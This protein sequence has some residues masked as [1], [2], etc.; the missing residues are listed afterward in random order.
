VKIAIV[1]AGVL[2]TSLGM[3]LQRAGHSL[4]ALCSRTKKKAK[5]AAGHL[6]NVEVVGDPGL[7]AMGAD[8]VLLAVPDRE[9]EGVVEQVVAGGALKRGA[10]VAHLAGGLPSSLLDAVRAAGAHRGSLHPLQTFA[11]VDT[12]VRLLPETYFCVEGDPEAVALLRSLA[13]GIGGQV[14]TLSAGKKALY[15]AGAVAASNF[16][17]TLVDFAVGLLV[18]AGVP[19]KEALPALLPLLKGTV[20][21]LAAVGLPG[22]LTGPIARGD[23]LTVERHMEALKA[24][25]GD[26]V[27]LYRELA[28]KNVEL[29]LRKGTVDKRQAER[30][31][32]VV[33]E[34]D[35]RRARP[36]AA[37]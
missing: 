33:C 23:T 8:L 4:V 18:Q 9:I 29:A 15:H 1:G 32:D 6:G 10:V 3:L 16:V 20:A 7:A 35:D 24:A 21:N 12:A 31:L 27:R 13:V 36:E 25:P 19:A 14:V 28:R 22:A 26:L 34:D 17:V 11:D 37:P 2:G 30:L 5:A